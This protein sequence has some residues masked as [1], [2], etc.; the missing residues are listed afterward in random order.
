MTKNKRNK[1]NRMAHKNKLDDLKFIYLKLLNRLKEKQ[2]VLYSLRRFYFMYVYR[3]LT[4]S[5]WEKF[6]EIKIRIG[7]RLFNNEVSLIFKILGDLNI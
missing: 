3:L 7:K 1:I 4:L 6:R 5:Y 2:A